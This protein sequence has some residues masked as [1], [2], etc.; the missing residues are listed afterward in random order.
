MATATNG[1]QNSNLRAGSDCILNIAYICASRD[2]PRRTGYHAIPN[3]AG[4]VIA[5]LAGTQQIT[6]ESPVEQRVDF[7]TGFGHLALSS[8]SPVASSSQ[9]KDRNQR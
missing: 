9:I 5:G 1:G 8:S 7:F 4:G 6:F 2:Q 3:R